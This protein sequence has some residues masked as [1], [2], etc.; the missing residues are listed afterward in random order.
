MGRDM[1]YVIWGRRGNGGSKSWGWRKERCYN[2]RLYNV[3]I[4]YSSALITNISYYPPYLI[5]HNIQY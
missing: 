3:Y 2:L 4:G 1:D 5:A